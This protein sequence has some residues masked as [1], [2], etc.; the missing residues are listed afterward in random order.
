MMLGMSQEKLATPFLTFQQVQKYERGMNRMEASRLQQAADILGVAVPFFSRGL[1]E[2][3]TWP[4]GAPR[5]RPM[6]TSSSRATMGYGSRKH[7]C[8]FRGREVR[9]R[10]VA[11]V[12]EIA[13]QE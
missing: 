3:L 1:V 9:Q 10:I 4:M 7:L 5:R 2:G 8:G 11:L 6:S 13:G 12:N